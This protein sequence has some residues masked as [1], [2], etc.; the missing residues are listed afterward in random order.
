MIQAKNEFEN[1]L[2]QVE[3][4]LNDEKFKNNIIAQNRKKI[5]MTFKNMINWVY[6]NPNVGIQDYQQKQSE[7]VSI[8]RPIFGNAMDEAQQDFDLF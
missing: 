2:Y 1:M 3:N 5:E 4:G 7:F 6:S 8:W